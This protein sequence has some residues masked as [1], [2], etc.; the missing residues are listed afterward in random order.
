MKKLLIY[1]KGYEKETVLAPLFK[2]LEALFEL[3]VPLVMAAV[4]DVG[5]GGSNRGYIVRM[6]LILVALGV[7]GLTCSI[8]A[9]YFAA[10]AA[11]GFS[12]VLRKEL[13][14]HIQSLSYTEMDK[15]GTSTLMTRM[16]SDIN[17]VQ[18]GINLVLRLFPSFPVYR[19]W[20]HG[21]GIYGRCESGTGICHYDSASVHCSL[22]NYA[23]DHAHV[24]ESAGCT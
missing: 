18:S 15:I 3:F 13:F 23:L 24:S 17:Q 9:Q 5:I 6:C 12:T 21:D 11:T 2:M 16:T 4:I 20:C 14:G 7:I 19:I 22:W 1:L 10:K 8:T